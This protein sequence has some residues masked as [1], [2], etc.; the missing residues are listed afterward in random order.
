MRLAL[1][2]F[3]F[4]RGGAALAANKFGT[5]AATAG[6]QVELINQDN[7]PKIQFFKRLISLILS[8]AQYDANPAKHSLNL[9][10]YQPI[11]ES[12]KNNDDAV[13]HIHWINNDTLSVFDFDKIPFG[14]II[15]MH[16]EW[17]YCGAEHYS[18]IQSESKAFQIGYH[19][20]Q[21]GILGLPWN[22]IIWRVKYQKLASRSDL[23]VTV[24]SDWLAHRARASSVLRAVDIRL[25]PNPIDTDIFKPAILDHMMMLR[26]RLG[27]PDN[28]FVF[29]FGAFQGK[30]ARLKGFS[31]LERALK[32]LAGE[33]SRK[34]ASGIVLVDF[35][36]V[37]G[38][39]RLCGFRQISL[40][41]VKSASYL[42]SIFAMADCVVVPSLVESFGQVAAEALS[43][44]TPVVSF[45][46][47]GLAEMVVHMETGLVAKAFD[48][49]CLMRQLLKMFEMPSEQRRNMGQNGRKLV[50]DKF[51]YPVVAE[52]YFSILSEAAE[53]RSRRIK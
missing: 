15:T 26:H 52:Q 12:F 35:G 9:F 45:N 8:K 42:G 41:E 33:I 21:N 37:R 28:A 29:V 6:F 46:T 36:G 27:I 39:G 50:V 5:L 14:S 20:S 34:T 11:L 47:S 43:S 17:L 25:L 23:I 22:H 4:N 18:S 53:I 19:C 24:P 16:D 44:A 10:S 30:K 2:S 40:G 7:A 1:Y 13:H 49:H 32:L 51:A 38:E 3:S 31:Y 48:V